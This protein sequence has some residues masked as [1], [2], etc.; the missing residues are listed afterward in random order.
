MTRS[1][2]TATPW[3]SR[4]R[5]A[6]VDGAAAGGDPREIAL[7]AN[8]P[9]LAAS[10]MEGGEKKKKGDDDDDDGDEEEEEEEGR[11]RRED[12]LLE[13]HEWLGMR[14][15]ERFGG[16]DDPAEKSGRRRRS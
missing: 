13:G 16:D 12:W 7:R 4:R 5:P 8:R 15:A 1:A 9:W 2:P 14:I 3:V 10:T 11:R 6:I